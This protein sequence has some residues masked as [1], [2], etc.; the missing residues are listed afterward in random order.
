MV[1]FAC[2]DVAERRHPFE[3]MGYVVWPFAAMLHLWLLWRH[4]DEPMPARGYHAVGLWLFSALAAWQLGWIIS[5]IVQGTAVWR[6]IAWALVP[7][8]V[9]WVLATRAERIR[10][11]LAKHLE[12]YLRTG[13]A[14]IALFVW[15]WSIAVNFTSSGDPAPL[16]YL[17]L[18]N[19]LDLAQVGAFL[20]VAAWIAALGRTPF[21]RRWLG[22]TSRLYPFAAATVFIWLN[23]VL[24]RTLHHW[25]GVP[26]TGEGLAASMLV[27]ASLSIFWTSIAL[28]VMVAATRGGLRTLWMAGAGLMGAVIAKLFFVDLSSAGGIERIVSFMGVG[29]LLLVV[30]YFS[31][32]PPRQAR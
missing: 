3:A 4:E 5:D 11:P 22:R 16:P 26:F 1:L 12:A 6:A 10:W 32:V 28:C 25:A 19:P 20:A 8:L 18:L 21:G 14:P 15:G 27:Q 30:G 2:I 13:A 23:G 29:L 7:A 24:L 9:L 31:P 17:P